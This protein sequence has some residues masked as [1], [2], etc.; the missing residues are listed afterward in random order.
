MT[1]RET[2]EVNEPAK[3]NDCTKYLFYPRL[4]VWNI[5]IT[6]ATFNQAKTPRKPNERWTIYQHPIIFTKREMTVS[7]AEQRQED[8]SALK[9]ALKPDKLN[10]YLL[11]YYCIVI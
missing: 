11:K 8:D 5:A 9:N 6:E 1:E 10:V 2:E 7:E 4:F 3:T